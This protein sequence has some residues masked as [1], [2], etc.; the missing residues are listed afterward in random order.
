MADIRFE[1]TSQELA[2][3]VAKAIA[4]AVAQSQKGERGAEISKKITGAAKNAAQT[5]LDVGLIAG[6]GIA[7]AAGQLY[8]AGATA[9]NRILGRKGDA[10]A[11]QSR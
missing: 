7:R 11:C 4:Q 6:V 5:A 10:S 1:L 9:V 3:I 8:M 2:D